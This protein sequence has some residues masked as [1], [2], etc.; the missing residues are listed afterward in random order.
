MLENPLN[1]NDMSL[2]EKDIIQDKD[3]SVINKSFFSTDFNFPDLVEKKNYLQIK[4]ENQEMYMQLHSKSIKKIFTLMSTT[5][6]ELEDN[7]LDY[8][9]CLIGGGDELDKQQLLAINSNQIVQNVLEPSYYE[10]LSKTQIFYI[11]ISKLNPNKKINKKIT[12]KK[13]SLEKISK[14]LN[15]NIYDMCDYIEIYILS[16][17][18]KDSLGERFLLR[19]KIVGRLSQSLED[20]EKEKELFSGYRKFSVD[21]KK[22]QKCNKS[23]IHLM[24]F[25]FNN[26]WNAIERENVKDENLSYSQTPFGKNSNEDID[27]KNNINNYYLPSSGNINN[28]DNIRFNNKDININGEI[29]NNNPC[30]ENFC[31]NICKI[32]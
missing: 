2:S 1:I 29:K 19:A 15:M 28:I 5:Q 27:N 25:Y 14:Y 20:I 10:L 8:I 13:N 26:V 21:I 3:N 32:F 17:Q 31:A 22:A 30:G 23:K 7:Y 9:T 6:G 11:G 4:I 16:Y 12:L 24:D 18:E